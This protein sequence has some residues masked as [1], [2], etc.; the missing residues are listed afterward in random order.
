MFEKPSFKESAESKR[1]LIPID[2]FFEH[3]HVNGKPY[4]YFVQREDGEIMNLA[5]LQSE[6]K[7]PETGEIIRTFSIVTKPGNEF[8][9]IIHNNP[10]LE[11]PRMPF[12]LEDA[13]ID[14]WMDASDTRD[15][16]ALISKKSVVE[17]K[18]HPVQ[19]LKGKTATG[20]TE[21]VTNEV[22]YPELGATLFD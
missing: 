4:P 17:L 12:I 13:D 22:Y 3:K 11:G 1:C 7:S 21:A 19:K 10:K 15:I 20:N 6:W 18:A 5:G 2:G 14:A 16:E 8:M 9:S